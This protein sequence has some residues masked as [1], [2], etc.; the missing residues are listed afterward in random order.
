MNNRRKLIIAL[1]A[2][3][4]TAPF[5]SLA[6]QQ[7]KVWRI[8]FFYFGSRPSSLTTGRYHAFVQGMREL[9]Y[10]EGKNLLIETRFGDGGT[11]RLPVLAA[12][13]LKSKVDVIVATGSPVYSA[14]RHANTTIPIV[15]TVTADAVI[16]GLAASLARPG[17]N[18]TGLSDAAA[19][20]G[21]KQLELLMAAVP[22]LTRAGVLLNPDNGSHP[23]Q[24]Q[25]L[26]LAAQKIGVHVVVAKAAK[27]AEIEPGFATLAKE[28]ADAVILFGD[29]FFVQQTQQIAQTALK[30]RLPSI[31]LTHEHPQAGGLMSYGSDIVDNFRRAATYVDKILKGAKPGELPFEQPTRYLFA[32]NFKTAKALGLTIPQSLLLRADEVIQ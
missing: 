24:L 32:I 1:G 22:Q 11:Q 28:R 5:S 15:V 13:L 29:T 8:G 20:L 23:A 27:V 30:H 12:E 31:S 14:L 2:G 6:Q 25:G 4:L 16:E 26:T 18:F 19:I 10:D 7:G 3:A 21:P 9:G 17:G